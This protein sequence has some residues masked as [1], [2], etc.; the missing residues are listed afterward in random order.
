[1]IQNS[2]MAGKQTR[3]LVFLGQIGSGPRAV[4]KV[5]V[6]DAILRVFVAPAASLRDVVPFRPTRAS[7]RHISTTA[8]AAYKAGVLQD[9]LMGHSAH[10]RA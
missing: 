4:R 3:N 10:C 5:R 6:C 8:K 2:S 7:K 1:M 9:L